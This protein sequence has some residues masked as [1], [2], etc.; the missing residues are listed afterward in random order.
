[1]G[2]SEVIQVSEDSS[3]IW[4]V[5]KLPPPPAEDLN[6]LMIF[7]HPPIAVSSYLVVF[8]F[9]AYLFLREDRTKSLSRLGF[10]SWG[11]TLLTLV[12]GMIWAQSAWGNY[13]SWEPKEN[14]SLV[15]FIL[16]SAALVA[17]TEGRRNLARGLGLLSCVPILFS[18]PGIFALVGLGVIGSK[19][20]IENKET[21]YGQSQSS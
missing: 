14:T 8:A 3:V 9:T 11:L 20:M 16:I 17:F 19:P 21:E 12:T 7:I 2:V 15:L 6:P 10:A 18:L 13:W 5:S 1:M 4:E